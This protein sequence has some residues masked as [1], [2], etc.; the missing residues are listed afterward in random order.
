MSSAYPYRFIG[1]YAALLRT[2]LQP[3]PRVL[4][5]WE[6]GSE[7]VRVWQRGQVYLD[8]CSAQMAQSGAEDEDEDGEVGE[9]GT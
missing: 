6:H 5:V 2:P 8:V 9:D 1:T 7:Q 4:C 3:L